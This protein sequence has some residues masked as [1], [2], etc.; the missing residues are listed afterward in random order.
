MNTQA[1]KPTASTAGK[2]AS[3]AKATPKKAA[4][5]KV[6]AKAPGQ[7]FISAETYSA[8]IE[9][10]ILKLNAQ[11]QKARTAVD[12]AEAKYCLAVEKKETAAANSLKQPT[13]AKKNAALKAG[14]AVVSSD[15]ELQIAKSA[16]TKLSTTLEKY[17]QA[18]AKLASQVRRSVIACRVLETSLKKTTD[19]YNKVLDRETKLISKKIMDAEAKIKPGSSKIDK[20]LADK[21]KAFQELGKEQLK[22]R[23]LEITQ[24]LKEKYQNVK[25][26]KDSLSI[27]LASA[28]TRINKM[29]Q[30]KIDKAKATAQARIKTQQTRINKLKKSAPKDIAALEKNCAKQ[31][32]MREKLIGAKITAR[33][34]KA[35]AACKSILAKATLK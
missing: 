3:K 33:Q 26:P 14:R 25:M 1:T 6:A 30:G 27:A 19:R 24:Q 34:K 7:K 5:K 12:K 10:E 2:P 15:K 20:D 22:A 21:I 13:A 11:L 28:E 9:N 32:A 29:T 31:I 23:K 35:S 8:N 18:A 17:E 4:P 16:V